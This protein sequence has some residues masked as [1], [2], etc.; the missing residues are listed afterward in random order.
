[1]LCLGLT[2]VLASVFSSPSHLTSISVLMF[3]LNFFSAVQDIATDSLAVKIL[4]E[5][6]LGLGNTIQVRD[7]FVGYQSYH[8][9]YLALTVSVLLLHHCLSP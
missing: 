4:G 6:E 3:V 1:M 2:C 5:N 7:N 9:G 8:W